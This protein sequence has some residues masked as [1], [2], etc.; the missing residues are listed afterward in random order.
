MRRRPP[1]VEKLLRTT[2][3]VEPLPTGANVNF[4]VPL[5]VTRRKSV[6]GTAHVHPEA[7]LRPS[8][9][10]LLA[11]WLPSQSWF[12]ADPASLERVAFFRF[13]D[14]DGEV[15]IDCMILASNGC[16]FHVPVTWRAEPLEDGDLIGTL[17]HSVLGTRYC[18]DGPSDHVYIRELARV[19]RTCDSDADI[20]AEGTDE[21]RER[22]IAVAG[23]GSSS[24]GKLSEDPHVIRTLDGLW[25]TADA[26]L[27][28]TWQPA[29]AKRC[30]VLATLD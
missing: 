27:V 9:L 24:G 2:T 12:D 21:V 20:L 1:G 19:I 29:D 18:Y 10:E 26:H 4:Q 17:E 6:S 11:G 30:D 22:S 23:T 25:P 13:V 5:A 28:A 14:P 16:Y 15:G 8:K 7:I 3:T